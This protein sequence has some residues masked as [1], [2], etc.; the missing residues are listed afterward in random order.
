M[1]TDFVKSA[2]SLCRLFGGTFK[3]FVAIAA[4]AFTGAAWAD[5]E[6]KEID[7]IRWYYEPYGDGRC[8]IYFSDAEAAVYPKPSGEV[9]VPPSLN[10]LTVAQIGSH[11][12]YKCT[13]ITK[14]TIPASG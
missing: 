10:G 1:K 3:A 12:F 2:R 9:T 14:I 5:I 7:G 4:I 13:D 8:K 11:A 6:Y